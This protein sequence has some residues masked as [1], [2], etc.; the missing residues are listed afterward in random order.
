MATGTDF[1][2]VKVASTKHGFEFNREPM[3]S[4]ETKAGTIGNLSQWT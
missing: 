4:Y 2:N 3:S 1:S